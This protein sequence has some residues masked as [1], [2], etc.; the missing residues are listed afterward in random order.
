MQNKTLFPKETGGNIRTTQQPPLLLEEVKHVA[1]T[2]ILG[3]SS[4]RNAM[5]SWREGCFL[6]SLPAHGG[7]NVQHTNVKC[8][9]SLQMKNAIY[10]SEANDI[11]WVWSPRA[12]FILRMQL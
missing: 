7:N 6:Y 8:S 10:P 11:T 1:P 9:S 12:N 4:T 3:T 5:E 2:D